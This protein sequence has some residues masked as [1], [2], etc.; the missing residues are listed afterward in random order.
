[1]LPLSGWFWLGVVVLQPL[2]LF[3]LTALVSL[4]DNS[5]AGSA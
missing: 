4:W 5:G 3:V 2:C 1:M